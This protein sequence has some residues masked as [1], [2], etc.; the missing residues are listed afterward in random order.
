[1]E[2]THNSKN[3]RIDEFEGEISDQQSHVY[4]EEEENLEHHE[5]KDGSGMENDKKLNERNNSKE[6]NAL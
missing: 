4:S 5:L 2:A 3:I 6:D 1:M